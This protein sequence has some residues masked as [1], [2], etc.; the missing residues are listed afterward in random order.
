[1]HAKE[2]SVKEISPNHPSITQKKV[3]SH[4]RCVEIQNEKYKK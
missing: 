1:M 2:W 4:K 3:V